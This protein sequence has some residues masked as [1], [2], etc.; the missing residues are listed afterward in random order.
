MYLWWL[1][2]RAEMFSVAQSMWPFHKSRFV[3]SIL[4]QYIWHMQ[5]GIYLCWTP[6]K[7][8]FSIRL[9]E[10]TRLYT[11]KEEKSIV[12]MVFMLPPAFLASGSAHRS[13]DQPAYYS[14][15]AAQA[16]SAFWIQTLIKEF[17]ST[18]SEKQSNPDNVFCEWQ[19]KCW[20]DALQR[21]H[22]MKPGG[23]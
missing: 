16:A 19:A 14:L 1:D 6:I 20:Q 3:C 13:I 10:Y 12:H 4:A 23:C 15:S 8:C 5:K 17:N 21:L 9:C 7:I 18:K 2:M 22:R 11:E